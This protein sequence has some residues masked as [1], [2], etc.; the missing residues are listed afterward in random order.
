MVIFCFRFQ[1]LQVSLK[2]EETNGE[3]WSERMKLG[4]P[5]RVMISWVS[6][7][8]MI[9]AVAFLSGKSCHPPRKVI[10]EY[11][12]VHIPFRTPRE[13]SH[14]IQTDYLERLIHNGLLKFPSHLAALR[15]VLLA[16]LAV[17]DKLLDLEAQFWPEH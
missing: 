12:Q 11:Q 14:Q 13:G 6:T 15:F 7:C 2:T 16:N 1:E 4:T 5:H 3:P 8:D 9:W 17:L 10:Q